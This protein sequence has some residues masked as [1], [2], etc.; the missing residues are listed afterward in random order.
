MSKNVQ[1]IADMV[2]KK[3]RRIIVASGNKKVLLRTEAIYYLESVDGATFAYLKNQVYKVFDG[4]G[5][6]AE[7]YEYCVFPRCSKSMVINVYKIN[8]LR[9]EP[10]NR[11]RATMENGE[12][13]I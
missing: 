2:Q 12:Q 6:L 13:V 7:S 3:E 10:G 11:I 5:S 8:H 4:L 9:S 1:A